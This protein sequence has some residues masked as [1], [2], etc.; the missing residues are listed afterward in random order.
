MCASGQLDWEGMDG[1][2]AG[3]KAAVLTISD[4][5]AAGTQVD[6]SG[7]AV[8]KI[9]VEAGLTV[10]ATA[11]LP[12]DLDGISRA[13][14]DYAARVE[15][16]V[17]TGGTGLAPRDV[18]PEATRLVCDRLVDGLSERMRAA[19]LA[20]TPW[21]P[22]SRSV[23]GCRGATLIVNLPGSPAGAATSLKAIL[24]LLPHALR[25]LTGDTGHDEGG[26]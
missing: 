24:D 11:T 3:L 5:C 20:E 7:P 4:R 10:A 8:A 16:I 14:R 18:T 22:L 1:F 25:L 9:L 12:D 17:T 26:S 13:L 21:S 2:K 19:G 15:L 23:C 6:A